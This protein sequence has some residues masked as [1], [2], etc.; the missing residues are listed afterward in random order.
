MGSLDDSL[1]DIPSGSNLLS[2]SPLGPSH[3]RTG[4]YGDDLSLSELDQTVTYE[5]PPSG[6]AGPSTPTRRDGDGDD[7]GDDPDDPEAAEK[8][9]RLA[10]KRREDK[11]QND[12]FILRKL[13]STF[14]ALSESLQ[15]AHEARER[16]A[17]QLE[18]TDALLNRYTKILSLSEDYSRLILDEDWQGGEQD[19]EEWERERREEEARL[20]REAEARAEA[21]RREREKREREEAERAKQEERERLI[22][23]RKERQAA[24]GTV[25]GVRGTRASMRGYARGSARG[26]ATNAGARPGSASGTHRGTTTARRGST[27]RGIPRPG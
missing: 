7:E 16:V 17:L 9:R 22:R 2:E 20:R 11:L 4:P 13:N 27:S 21:E 24:R 12:L 26:A 25:T 10:S 23:E 1:L 3:S 14:A 5:G 8:R 19:E 6:D 15:E 18:Q